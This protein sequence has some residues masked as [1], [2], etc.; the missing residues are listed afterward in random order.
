MPQS[1]RE[2]VFNYMNALTPEELAQFQNKQLYNDLTPSN[3]PDKRT[4]AAHKKMLYTYIVQWKNTISDMKSS[5]LSSKT[6]TKV[7]DPQ[8]HKN[9]HAALL[10][11]L[12]NDPRSVSHSPGGGLDSLSFLT[13]ETIALLDV[14]KSI[15]QWLAPIV[16]AQYNDHFQKQEQLVWFRPSILNPKQNDIVDTMMDST[17]QVIVV[18]GPLRS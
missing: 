6:T 11:P 4:I 15:P 8:S 16:M 13:P 14:A 18:T 2:R 17:T 7:K 12:P 1:V 10:T 3:L 9:P 5:I